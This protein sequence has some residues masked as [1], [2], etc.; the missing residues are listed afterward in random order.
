MTLDTYIRR[1]EKIVTQI[2]FC[3]LWF[4]QRILNEK[5]RVLEQMYGWKN[6]IPLSRLLQPSYHAG[7]VDSSCC[8]KCLGLEMVKQGRLLLTDWWALREGCSVTPGRWLVR[9]HS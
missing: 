7:G 4:R 8:I 5:N 3:V 2:N 9:P 6:P 1:I